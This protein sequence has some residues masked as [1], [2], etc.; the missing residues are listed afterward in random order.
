MLC[1]I[2]DEGE[3]DV[4]I[5]N[6]IGIY[7]NPEKGTEHPVNKL[8]T[9]A[10]KCDLTELSLTL[11]SNKENRK[12]TYVHNSCRT[13]LKNQARPNKR[14]STCDDQPSSSKWI[15]EGTFDFKTKCF[16]CENSCIF[17][18]KYP[19]RNKF[20]EVRTILTNLYKQTLDICKT[21]NDDIA[22][23][24]KTRLVS[25]SDLVAAEA[26]YHVACRTKF[27]NPTSEYKTPGRPVS[28]TKI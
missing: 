12:T 19:D 3:K 25:V 6:Q 16:F 13:K 4:D 28:S 20:T 14:K 1:V 2:C 15:S 7:W 21:R 11:S 17:D 27:E 10:T 22:K 23:A 26:R 9:Q 5:L 18:K 24:I 8:I